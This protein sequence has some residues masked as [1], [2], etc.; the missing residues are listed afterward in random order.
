[1]AIAIPAI[2]VSPPLPEHDLVWILLKSRQ[3]FKT[4]I[5]QIKL[6]FCKTKTDSYDMWCNLA[7]YNWICGPT[8]TTEM[9][10]STNS[11]VRHSRHCRHLSASQHNINTHPT[12]HICIARLVCLLLLFI[13]IVIH[14]MYRK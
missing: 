11:P 9:V 1:M 10:W 6:G 7:W 4:K 5:M 2:L 13:V 12:F 14:S 8:Q 3:R